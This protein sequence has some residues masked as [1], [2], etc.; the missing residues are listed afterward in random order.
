MEA[1]A[2]RRSAASAACLHAGLG[3]AILGQKRVARR[4]AIEALALDPFT[5]SPRKVALLSGCS[6]RDSLVPHCDEHSGTTRVSPGSSP[7]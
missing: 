7:V 3:S 6:C 5:L 1:S 4:Y 2:V